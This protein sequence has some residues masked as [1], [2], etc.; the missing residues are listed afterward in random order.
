MSLLR[1]GYERPGLP[2]W[3]AL[4]HTFSLLNLCFEGSCYWVM[5]QP[6]RNGSQAASGEA[7][8]VGD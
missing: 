3:V 8:G 4:S 5:Q 2:S 1:L 6:P 7:H